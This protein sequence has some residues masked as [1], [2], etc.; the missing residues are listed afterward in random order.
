MKGR[1]R[2]VAVPLHVL[3]GAMLAI[4]LASACG[5]GGAGTAGFVDPPSPT[6]TPISTATPTPTPTSKP[7]ATPTPTPTPPPLL[8]SP[9]VL[10]V[11]ST[12]SQQITATEIG[13]RGS[14]AVT[15]SDASVVTVTTPI[16]STSDKTSIPIMVV[17]AGTATITIRDTYG[18]SASVS[19]T[20]TLVPVTIGLTGV[21]RE[22]VAH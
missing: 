19:V 4:G 13:Y 17:N 21:K 7:T 9:S 5:G 1:Q 22:W 6:S 12:G 15:A 20:V 2:R 3:F 8:A 14:F 16:Q 11:E 18:Q 10:N